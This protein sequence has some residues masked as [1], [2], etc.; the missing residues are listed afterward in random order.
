MRFVS[1]RGKASA[2]S[3]GTA[4]VSLHDNVLSTPLGL[5]IGLTNRISMSVMVPFVTA[6]SNVNFLMNPT[7]LE[8]TLGFN[9]LLH[10]PLGSTPYDGT[11]RIDTGLP[12]G[13]AKPLKVTF[14]KAGT[15]SYICSIHPF[16]HGTVVVT[17]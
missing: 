3:L 16:M 14:T 11:K 13:K 12:L 15:Y 1:T 10:G 7:G 6:T 17:P 2:A 9:P 4:L 5:E 8:P